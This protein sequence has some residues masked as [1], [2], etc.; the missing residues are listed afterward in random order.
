MFRFLARLYLIWLVIMSVVLL[1]D[2]FWNFPGLFKS[3]MEEPPIILALVLVLIVVC[4]GI[5]L[6]SKK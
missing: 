1:L 2:K 4:V 3:F 6:R 5:E